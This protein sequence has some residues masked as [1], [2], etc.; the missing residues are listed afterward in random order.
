MPFDRNQ[1]RWDNSDIMKYV[2]EIPEDV[3]QALE[4]RAAA[5]GNDVAQWIQM[6]VVSFVRR[7]TGRLPDPPLEDVGIVAPCDLPRN[8]ARIVRAQSHVRRELDPLLD[9]E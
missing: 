8:T 4:D 6:V 7:G 3:E 9:D 2:V 5:S 1:P